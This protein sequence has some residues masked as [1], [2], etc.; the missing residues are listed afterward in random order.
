MSIVH[1]CLQD[2]RKEKDKKSEKDKKDDKRE[3]DDKRDRDKK[4]DEDDE[5][6]DD[7]EEEV[8]IFLFASTSHLYFFCLHVFFQHI[9][10]EKI[11]LLKTTSSQCGSLFFQEEDDSKDRKDSGKRKKKR[12]RVKLCTEDPYLLLSFVYFD[13]THCGYIFDKDIEELLF[14]LGLNL[15]RAQV[16]TILSLYSKSCRSDFCC[17][18]MYVFLFSMRDD[19]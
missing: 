2:R 5:D 11:I 7:Y 13:Q 3:K 17:I 6:D 19:I 16:R 12:E 1:N 15:S 9:V 4:S 18:N 14:T 8:N 10:W